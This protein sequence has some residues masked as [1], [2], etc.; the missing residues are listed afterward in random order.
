MTNYQCYSYSVI[1]LSNI[2]KNKIELTPETF[3]HELYRL[4]NIYSEDGI[5]KRVKKLEM[6]NEL[7]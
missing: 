1:A 5:E 7:F 2:L 4:W 3:Y 6:N